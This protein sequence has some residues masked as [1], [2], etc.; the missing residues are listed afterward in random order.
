MRP[1]SRHHY[2]R[3]NR[4][5]KYHNL[6]HSPQHDYTSIHDKNDSALYKN[7][8]YRLHRKLFRKLPRNLHCNLDRNLHRNLHRNPPN[9]NLHCILSRNVHH[10]KYLLNDLMCCNLL[11][12]NHP[13]LQCLTKTT[14]IMVKKV[15]IMC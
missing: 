15:Y 1:P 13:S 7:L 10:L 8:R 9:Q 6:C 11:N 3:H 2:L 4:H 14:A 12:H 5:L